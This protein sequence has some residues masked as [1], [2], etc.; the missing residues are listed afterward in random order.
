MIN[1]I[2]LL[3]VHPHT[4]TYTPYTRLLHYLSNVPPQYTQTSHLTS[5]HCLSLSLSYDPRIVLFMLTRMPSPWVSCFLLQ[6]RALSL[7]VFLVALSCRPPFSPLL[8]RLS[9]SPVV[10]VWF[11]VLPPVRPFCL[12][13]VLFLLVILRPRPCISEL[14]SSPLSW[15]SLFESVGSNASSFRANPVPSS[16]VHTN[17]SAALCPPPSQCT[18]LLPRPDTPLFHSGLGWLVKVMALIC[19]ITPH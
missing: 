12:Q 11:L 2:L 14:S 10:S 13:S 15:S 18:P 8:R 1:Y 9:E 5:V 17:L 16:C 6:S 3:L 19:D 4:Y 7:P